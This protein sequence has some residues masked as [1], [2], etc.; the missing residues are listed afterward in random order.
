M[1]WCITLL[2]FVTFLEIC[3]WQWRVVSL[4]NTDLALVIDRSFFNFNIRGFYIILHLFSDIV[5]TF[6]DGQLVGRSKL[7]HDPQLPHTFPYLFD[8]LVLE[9]AGQCEVSSLVNHVD[10]GFIIYKHGIQDTSTVEA[11]NSSVPTVTS[12]LLG[13]SLCVR[14]I[15]PVIMYLIKFF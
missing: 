15:L 2:W 13:V 14:H 3:L 9:K 5:G 1:V 8:G 7:F 12:T 10:N 4:V 11:L 6:I